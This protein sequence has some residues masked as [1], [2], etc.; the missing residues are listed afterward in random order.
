MK[1]IAND[2]TFDLLNR[3]KKVPKEINC[4]VLK[5]RANQFLDYTASIHSQFLISTHET[6]CDNS[7]I[8]TTTEM[9]P[10]S[11]YQFHVQQTVSVARFNGSKCLMSNIS[12]QFLKPLYLEEL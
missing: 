5:G 7:G 9:L 2:P 6:S 11:K 10:F 1:A 3:I 12:Y 4:K 8:T